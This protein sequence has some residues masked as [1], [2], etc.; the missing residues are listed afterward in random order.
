MSI[1]KSNNNSERGVVLV[2]VLIA[3]SILTIL[4]SEFTFNTH[5]DFEISTNNLNE[6]KAKYIGKSG[7]EVVAGVLKKNDLEDLS[8]LENNIE[9]LELNN[10]DIWSINLPSF[11]VGDG[12]VSIKVYDERSKINLN[13]LVNTSTNKIDF[14]VLTA[15]TELFKILEVDSNKSDLFIASLINWID[16]EVRGAQDDQDPRGA[17]GSFY[18]NLDNGY[19]IKNGSLDSIDE[20]RMI[21]GIDEEFFNKVRSYITI[22]P[23]NKQVNFSTAP[24]QVIIAALKAAEVSAIQGQSN[25]TSVNQLDDDVAELIADEIIETRESE[26][27]ISRRETRDIIRRV[28][29]TLRLTAGL[30]GM[31]LN[32]GTSDTFSVETVGIVGEGDNPT[33]KQIDAVLKKSGSRNRTRVKIISWKER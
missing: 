1:N 2:I 10:T 3:I 24:R 7:V 11:P 15:L 25:S 29:P 12:A 16:S 4:V 6:I 5:I 17:S 18:T 13:S 23:Q 19:T 9:D 8:G 22:Y 32:K 28:D 30:S 26:K 27:I 31:V 20:V 14:Q 33:I 21:E